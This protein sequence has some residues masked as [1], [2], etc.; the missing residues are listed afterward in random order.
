MM[1]MTNL[2]FKVHSQYIK[3]AVGAVL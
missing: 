1:K 2:T 3:L